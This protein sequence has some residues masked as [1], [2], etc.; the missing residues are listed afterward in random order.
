MCCSNSEDDVR[1]HW[2]KI[3]V[4]Y[5]ILSD[6]KARARYDRSEMIADPA[7]AAFRAATGATLNG[8]TSIGRGLFGLGAFALGKINGDDEQK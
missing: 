4:A 5:E 2:E 3:R 6:K 1:E 7:G 8:V